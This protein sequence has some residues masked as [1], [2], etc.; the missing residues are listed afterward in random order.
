LTTQFDISAVQA[1]NELKENPIAQVELVQPYYIYKFV[2][3]TDALDVATAGVFI[4][5]IKPIPFI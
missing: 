3:T 4:Q 1:F 2:L 5:Y